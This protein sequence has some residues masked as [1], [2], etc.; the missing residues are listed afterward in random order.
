MSQSFEQIER[1]IVGKRQERKFVATRADLTL[2]DEERTV[3]ISFSSEQPVERWFGREVLDHSPESVML[4]RLNSS[5]PYLNNHD[6]DRKLG[7]V[8]PGSVHLYQAARKGRCTVRYSRRQAAEDEWQDV[9]DG[10]PLTISVGYIIHE[11]KLEK[12]ESGEKT[13]RATRWEPLEV[14]AV[15]VAADITVGGG[16][17]LE[18]DEVEPEPHA[19]STEE[20]I[21]PAPTPEPDTDAARA[22]TTIEV[23]KEKMSE[24]M[25][26]FEQEGRFFEQPG[27]AREFYAEGK[28]LDEFRRAVLDKKR[29][30]AV[31]PPAPK[32][33]VELNERERERYSI[34]RAILADA[35]AR[36]GKDD[37]SFER[38]VSD[39]IAR[40]LGG[41]VKLRGG[42]LIPTGIALRG[43]Q[44]QRT[45][46]TTGGATTGADAVF[47]EP[48]SFID[49]LRNRA[50][51]IQL[52]AT[53]LPGLQ[54]NVA[55]PKQTSAGSV[56]WVGENPGS[57]VDE[58]N[59]QLDQ[60]TLQPR[61]AMSTQAYS[62]Q[63]LRQAVVNIDALVTMDL[64]KTMALEIDRV[65]LH[66]S[67]TS[68]APT[69]LY[70]T[71]GVNS[72]AMGGAVTFSKIVQMETEIA[73]GN[74]DIGM[75]AYLTTPGV[76]GAA[77]T[78][79]KFSGTD[80]QPIWTGDEMNGYRAAA[81]NQ[82][83]KTLGVGMN[84][85][86]IVFGVWSEL[87]IGEWGAL[88]LITDPYAKKKQALIEVT[89]FCM[90][91]IAPKYGEAFCKGTGLTVS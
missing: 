40:K 75:M 64:A 71:S 23:R 69:G 63:L 31:N 20:S 30:E 54:G 60:V 11:L 85:H 65:A 52:G 4:D 50:M 22:A 88:E 48:G 72:V 25:E 49:L 56:S 61:S 8:L 35:D 15:P 1:S 58:S 87:L 10:A 79:Q 53:L 18:S 70:T 24:L 29:A 42:I 37:N 36:D 91:D 33:V 80:G 6:T 44:M 46:L 21:T 39:E 26:Q 73:S 41:D 38:E 12:S 76:R 17:S 14:S 82:V 83:S 81:S 32:P 47:T 27:M 78:T 89:S 55:F 77:K 3:E 28:T 43:L 74:A 62:R 45:P 84:E 86:G 13:Y 68:N 34:S 16:R 9:R 67:G 57:D 51:V 90:V 66:G 2:N 59:I 19:P 7:W 5:G